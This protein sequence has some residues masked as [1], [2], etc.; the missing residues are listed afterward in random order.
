MMT[1]F[2]LRMIDLFLQR[3]KYKVY[4]VPSDI[5]NN[6]VLYSV[7]DRL[8]C[9]GNAVVHKCVNQVTGDEYAIKFLLYD[10]HK[11]KT[12]F[13]R[14]CS[15]LSDCPHAHIISFKGSG[16][17]TATHKKKGQRE[18]NKNLRFLI[19][20]F[21]D[22]GDLMK[23]IKGADKIKPEIY[24]SQFRGLAGAL[25]LMHQNGIIHRDI[26][27]QNILNVGNRWVISDFGLTAIVNRAQ[28]E[29]TKDNE[30]IGPRFWMSPEAMNRSIGIKGKAAKID[31][32]S[33]VFQLASFFW[34]VATKRHPSGI[35]IE[36]DWPGK[37]EVYNVLVKALQQ[38]PNNR[39]LDAT[40]F[41]NDLIEAIEA[42]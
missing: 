17:V 25:S 34:F 36:K 13:E 32:K 15:T 41:Q 39:Y 42:A 28:P 35:P 20:E 8:N 19:M 27:P 12:R 10:S 18:Y 9:G 6:G 38:N 21:S 2:G 26:K 7:E 29:L 22:N 5:T 16:E 31:K 11:N 3:E 4:K 40:A 14:E 23:C 24:H 30:N 37:K 33:D 1:T